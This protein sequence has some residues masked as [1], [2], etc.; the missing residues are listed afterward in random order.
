MI[1]LAILTVIL[2]IFGAHETESEF[3]KCLF[4]ATAF[5]VPFVMVF[6]L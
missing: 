5:M 6:Y 4:L 1:A 2:L 3:M